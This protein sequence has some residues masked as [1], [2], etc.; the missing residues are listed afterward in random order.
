MSSIWRQPTSSL[1]QKEL[2]W[3]NLMFANHDLWC[4]CD[5]PDLHMLICMNKFNGCPKP[6]EDIKNIKCLLTGA[7]TGEITKTEEEETG[8][9]SGDLE[10]LF[11]EDADADDTAENTR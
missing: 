6:E 2:Q 10:K 1:R 8:F 5:D 3:R 9:S 11:Q 7:T 4:Y